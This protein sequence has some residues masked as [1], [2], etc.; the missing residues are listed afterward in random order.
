MQSRICWAVLSVL[1]I[2]GTAY[3]AE[4]TLTCTPPTLNTDGSALVDL[5]GIRYF[6]AQNAGGPYTQIG[7]EPG[8]S[9]TIQRAAGTWYFVATAYNT[10]GTESDYSNEATKIVPAAIPAPPSGLTVTGSLLAYGISQTKDVLTVYPVGRV[11]LA[12]PCNGSITVQ[13]LF[14]VAYDA[15]IWSGSARPAV[16]LAECG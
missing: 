1:W 15:V 13:G 16:I 4:I 8:C 2:S 7:D 9:L 11:P 6:E 14:Q 5:A 10:A 3:G 12:T